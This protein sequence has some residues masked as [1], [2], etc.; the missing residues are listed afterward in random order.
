MRLNLYFGNFR[1][2]CGIELHGP[3]EGDVGH[4]R[5]RLGGRVL[6]LGDEIALVGVSRGIRQQRHA[7]LDAK[8][9]G[10]DGG[11]SGNVPEL[12]LVGIDVDGAV[13][14][15][16]HLLGQQHEEH[17]RHQ[18]EPRRR[19]YYLEGGAHGVGGG[20]AGPRHHPV[21]HPAEHHHGAVVVPVHDQVVG[22]LDS[23]ALGLSALEERF[24]HLRVVGRIGRVD[25]VAAREVHLELR[26]Q[27]LYGI[28][29]AEHRHAAELSPGEQA[30]GADDALVVALG[31]DDVLHVRTSCLCDGVLEQL[32]GHAH[33]FVGVNLL[34]DPIVVHVFLRY[35]LDRFKLAV[36]R[37]CDPPRPLMEGLDGFE[38][39][40]GGGED[41][42]GQAGLRQAVDH[43]DDHAVQLTR[44][45][46]DQHARH[47]GHPSGLEGEHEA[48][49]HLGAGGVGDKEAVGV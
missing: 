33:L 39:A 24:C 9:L 37:R 2:Y 26:G 44:A 34:G 17:A 46:A 23:H 11:G 31:Q 19:L 6:H 48:E 8:R 28:H 22:L 27:L 25:D 29:V 32:W 21:R 36:R 1:V 16:V 20:V 13:A 5:L 15:D 47:G 4:D 30:G 40:E 10:G 42:E 38:A 49:E 18:R 41:G 35:D 3:L 14:V 45:V 43:L 7:R 12:V